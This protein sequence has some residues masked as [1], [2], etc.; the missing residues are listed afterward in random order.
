MRCAV[1][2]DGQS[3]MLDKTKDRAS[4]GNLSIQVPGD[5]LPFKISL[6]SL[7]NEASVSQKQRGSDVP[8]R[9][10]SKCIDNR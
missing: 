1:H 9:E 3:V 10:F 5:R 2:R 7:T 8:V 4:I 6:I